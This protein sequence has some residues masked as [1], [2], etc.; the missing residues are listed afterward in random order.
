MV[1][2]PGSIPRMTL[3]PEGLCPRRLSKFATIPRAY[4]FPISLAP[5][6]TYGTRFGHNHHCRYRQRQQTKSAGVYET[7]HVRERSRSLRLH[8]S[9]LATRKYGRHL[10][11]IRFAF[12]PGRYNVGRRT[13]ESGEA[14]DGRSDRPLLMPDPQP[15]EDHHLSGRGGAALPCNPRGHHGLRPGRARVSEE[16][17]NQQGAGDHEP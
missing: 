3:P 15:T 11:S 6:P 8:S 16:Q 14:T 5:L 17:P 1:A 13:L 9:I 2:V 10:W 4:P 7:A 12:G